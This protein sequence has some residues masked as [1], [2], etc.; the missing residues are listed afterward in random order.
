MSIPKGFYYS[1]DHEWVKVEDGVGTIGITDFAQD[2]LG[3]I[4]FVELP[5]VG[6]EFDQEDN[7]GVIESVKAV[8]DLYMP[9]S[10]EVVEINED[11]LDQPELVNDEPYEGGWIIKVSLSDEAELDE[12]MNSDEYS[13]F[14]EEEA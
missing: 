6:D 5:Q 3:D 7:F 2:E 8:S 10:G 9:V 12:L 4:V 11:L 1:E 14:L 13:S